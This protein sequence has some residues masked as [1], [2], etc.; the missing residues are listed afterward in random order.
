MSVNPFQADRKVAGRL[1]SY[2]ADRAGALMRAVLPLLGAGILSAADSAEL[3][4]RF[5]L[6][7]VSDLMLLLLPVARSL[8][9]S[10][11]SQFQVGAIGLEADSGDL[12]FGH[13]VEFSGTHLG[14]TVHGETCLATRA[15]H[16]GSTLAV[17]ALG[18]AHPC[19]HCRQY[20]SEF[21]GS[22]DLV[23]IDPLGHRL[24]LG[25]L[26][27]WPFD[28]AYLGQ[29]GAVAGRD[30]WPNL[31]P[32]APMDPVLLA[33]GRRAHTPYSRCPSAV[34]LGMLDGS[35]V[36]GSAIESV[37]F[38]PTMGPLQAALIEALARGHDYGDIVSVTLAQVQ[39]GAVDHAAGTADLLAKIAPKA[40]LQV[41]GW[42]L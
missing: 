32:L 15:F 12:I 42:K 22:A 27:P 34:L 40:P 23:L 3:V 21:A 10:P 13:N 33:A 24:T 35:G 6:A 9:R 1:Q 41:Q 11:I 28:P 38:N 36:T 29:T 25:Q 18:E 8:A 5:D 19:A 14:L 31:T 26:Y 7:D 16:R 2:G 20:L 37:A 17:I 39:G 30:L 4:Q